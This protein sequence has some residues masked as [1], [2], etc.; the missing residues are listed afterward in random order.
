MQL[1]KFKKLKIILN[2][3]LRCKM[4]SQSEFPSLPKRALFQL[5]FW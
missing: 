1:E 5:D 4:L 3:Y 2:K